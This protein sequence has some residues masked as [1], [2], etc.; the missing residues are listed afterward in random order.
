M[1]SV[2]ASFF[3]D[4]V[5]NPA[6]TSHAGTFHKNFASLFILDRVDEPDIR[7]T[8]AIAPGILANKTA[9]IRV[10]D[11]EVS[12]NS[13]ISPTPDHALAQL[14]RTSPITTTGTS[15]K[16]APGSTRHLLTGR[17]RIVRKR[18][19][20][21]EWLVAERLCS[22]EG[23]T[24]NRPQYG[25]QPHQGKL[26]YTTRTRHVGVA[27]NFG[28]G[29]EVEYQPNRDE[30]DPYPAH[31]LSLASR[32]QASLNIRMF[33]G[34]AESAS[35]APSCFRSHPT[36]PPPAHRTHCCKSPT[37]QNSR[38]GACRTPADHT[39]WQCAS[40]GFRLSCRRSSTGSSRGARP[41]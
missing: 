22:P 10:S 23:K 34:N 19:P 9:L 39:R 5:E 2:S 8:T 40:P 7:F 32:Q 25:C 13:H 6:A 15:I 20:V 18:G 12:W 4:C 38:H 28:G 14:I 33:A 30:G 27:K 1:A 16:A 11:E 37:D 3:I 21:H 26:G 29:N 36:P 41:E 17:I 31:A 24:E 35:S